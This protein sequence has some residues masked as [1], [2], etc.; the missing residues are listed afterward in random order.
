M[1]QS[2][3]AS[4]NSVCPQ[5]EAPRVGVGR[6]TAGGESIWAQ[7]NLGYRKYSGRPVR[8]MVTVCNLPHKHKA[9]AMIKSSISG[10]QKHWP[11]WPSTLAVPHKL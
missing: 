11:S 4:E 8:S 5:K 2:P 3:I 7:I 10:R 1:W 6:P 9:V